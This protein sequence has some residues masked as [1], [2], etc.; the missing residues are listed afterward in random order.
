MKD[1]VV[2]RRPRRDVYIIVSHVYKAHLFEITV[3]EMQND[4]CAKADLR[5]IYDDLI[6]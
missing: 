5:Q 4:G 3:D 1:F 2:S 6:K